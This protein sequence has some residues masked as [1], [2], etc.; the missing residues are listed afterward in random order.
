MGL[1]SAPILNRIH[2]AGAALASL[3]AYADRLPGITAAGLVDARGILAARYGQ[4]QKLLPLGDSLAVLRAEQGLPE[5][6]PVLEA[7]ATSVGNLPEP[8]SQDAARTFLVIAQERFQT[9]QSARREL[10]NARAC[11]GRSADVFRIFGEVSTREL[12]AIYKRVE[13]TFSDYY[14]EL[15]RDDESKFT[16]KLEPSLGKLGFDVDFYGRGHFPPGAYH[17]EGHQ[18]S[19]GLCLYLALMGD[20]LGGGFTFAVLDDVRMS[21]DAGH[22]REVCRLLKQ[23]F[24]NTQFVF[25]THDEI[26]LRHMRSEGLVKGRNFAHF[27]TWTVDLGPAEWD[28][29][30]VWAEVTDHLAKNDVRGAAALLRHYLEHFSKEVCDRLRASVEFRGDAQFMLNDLLPAATSTYGELLKK[31]KVAANSW[32]QK[33][34]LVDI[35]A[36]EASYV[37]ARSR[38]LVDQWQVN[39]AVHFNAWADFHR[40]DFEPLV[41]AFKDLTAAFVCP[42]C[43]EV[44]YVSPER[45]AKESLRCGCAA[46]NLNL[47]AKGA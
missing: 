18:D 17:S 7:L 42:M 9:L 15:N 21:V 28:D 1:T 45:G 40:K 20:L 35:A 47:L 30:D 23:S 38:S 14:R 12:E 10:S 34:V 32:G 25:T 24:P 19:M 22:R 27:R 5:L 44:Y 41:Q 43:E 13:G 8:S 4:L 2:A 29:R 39:A 46:M 3:I 37:N 26:W 6:A 16:A 31:A 33:Q 36:I 11:A